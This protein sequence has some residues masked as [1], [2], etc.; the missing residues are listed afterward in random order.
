MLRLKY[1][2]KIIFLII[3][4]FF[5]FSASAHIIVEELGNMSKSAAATTYLLAGFEHILPLGLDHILFI[6]SLFLLNPQLKPIL[7]QSA[8]FT[9]AHSVTLIL[10]SY[11][12]ITPPAT[13]VEPLIALSIGYIAIENM[14]AKTLRPTRIVVVFLFGLLHGMGFAG[15]LAELGLPENAYLISLIS[16]NI[17]VE[18]GQVTIIL[19]SYIFLAIWFAKKDW[20]H[21]RIV[22]PI[23]AVIAII[24]L[25]WTVERIIA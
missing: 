20:Y 12:I 17:G 18:L 24:A 1:L 13:I 3:G 7:I 15:A 11:A 9:V 14:F 10:S 22:I 4:L 8:V 2:N 23:S 6:L 19:L 21:A 16:F 25:Y 5:T